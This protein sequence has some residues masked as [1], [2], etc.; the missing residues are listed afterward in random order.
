MNRDVMRRIAAAGG[1]FFRRARWF[2]IA[3]ALLAAGCVS[4]NKDI[5]LAL[6]QIEAQNEKAF[7]DYQRA[8]ETM[9]ASY[10]ENGERIAAREMETLILT[11]RA[12]GGVPADKAEEAFL[13][14]RD[15]MKA[16]Q[17]RVSSFDAEVGKIQR[18]REVAR[19]LMD[20][21]KYFHDGQDLQGAIIKTISG[22]M[23]EAVADCPYLGAATAATGETTSDGK[24]DCSGGGTCPG[25]TCATCATGGAK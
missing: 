4:A 11:N 3:L 13:R 12:G 15:N 14:Y 2:V 8:L 5:R 20:S 22:V 23:E 24:S 7:G 19:Q 21:V 25:T 1:R 10:L 16:F 6:D 9:R 17:A 18:R